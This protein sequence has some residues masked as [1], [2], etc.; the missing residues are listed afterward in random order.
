MLGTPDLT[1]GGGDGGGGGD[2]CGDDC[3]DVSGHDCG[4]AGG[5][6]CG[7]VGGA[8]MVLWIVEPHGLSHRPSFAPP[9]PPHKQTGLRCRSA[10]CTAKKEQSMN[11]ANEQH[12]DEAEC[13][14]GHQC[15][16]NR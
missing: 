4:D 8:S 7:D 9:P 12:V 6:D 1:G 5:D 10:S 11:D 15:A 13:R 3:G 2:D 16:V 14:H